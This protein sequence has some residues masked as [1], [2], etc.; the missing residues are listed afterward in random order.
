M[1]IFQEKTHASNQQTVFYF[2]LLVNLEKKNT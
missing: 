1:I 2:T